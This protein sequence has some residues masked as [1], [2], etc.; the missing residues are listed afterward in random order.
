MDD[1]EKAIKVIGAI[2]DKS[3]QD[4]DEEE[5]ASVGESTSTTAATRPAV[6]PMPTVLGESSDKLSKMLK[7]VLQDKVSP[8]TPSSSRLL[9]K[10]CTTRLLLIHTSTSTH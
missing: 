7:N 1:L 8:M 10:M 6:S 9:I 3:E 4:E 2:P 5:G